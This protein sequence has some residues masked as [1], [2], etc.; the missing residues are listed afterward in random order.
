MKLIFIYN[1][2]GG[3]LR[4]LF[5]LGHKILSPETYECGLC[6]LTHGAFTEREAWKK[7]R[8]GSAVEMEFLH[9]DEFE[10]G[11]DMNYDYPVVLAEGKVTSVLVD[12]N[13]IDKCGDVKML[14]R[15]IESKLALMT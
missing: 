2:S 1:A 8:E 5:D 4:G 10:R 11:C 12:K 15:M 7:F 6:K 14:I 13:E 9:K 3:K